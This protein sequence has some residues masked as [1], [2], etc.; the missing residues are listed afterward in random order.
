MVSLGIKRSETFWNRKIVLG[1]TP[2]LKYQ[3]RIEK[4][5]NE[6]D[7]RYYHVPCPQC[8]HFQTLRWENLRWDKTE[9]GEHLPGTAHFVCER[10]GCII[11]EA[12]KPGMI[13][14]GEWR[15]ERPFTG[16]AGFHIW[17]A[18]SLFPNATW[19]DIVR[20]FLAARA[21]P[22]LLRTWTTSRRASR[23]KTAG[24]AD[25]GKS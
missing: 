22:I 10:N 5:F 14:A 15:A 7:Q 18:Y 3:S 20:E 17:T 6:S 13:A 16:H 4:A 23:G 25:P 19:A 8:G 12:D 21:D 2:L 24:P 11:R 1:S 9:T